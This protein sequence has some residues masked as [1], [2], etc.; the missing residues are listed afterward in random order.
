MRTAQKTPVKY[1]Y[2][3]YVYF[4]QELTYNEWINLYIELMFM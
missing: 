3:N 1:K 4:K 2:I